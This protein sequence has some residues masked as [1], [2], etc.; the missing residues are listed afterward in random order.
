MF[1]KS[2]KNWKDIYEDKQ[3]FKAFFMYIVNDK[4]FQ[5]WIKQVLRNI[6]RKELPILLEEAEQKYQ[7]SQLK[8]EKQ[9]IE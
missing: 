5:N 3:D 2:K 9:M 4:Y 6:I 8:K 1:N 7:L